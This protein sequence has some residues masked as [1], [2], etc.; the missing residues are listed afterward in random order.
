[1]RCTITLI[2]ILFSSQALADFTGKYC[3][4]DGAETDSGEGVSGYCWMYSDKWGELDGA[5]TDSGV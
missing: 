2:A 1:M 3:E 4:L 5:E